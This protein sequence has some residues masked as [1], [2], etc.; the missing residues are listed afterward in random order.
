MKRSHL[1]LLDLL[2]QDLEATLCPGRTI[3]SLRGL[4]KEAAGRPPDYFNDAENY[5]KATDEALKAQAAAMKLLAEPR[6]WEAEGRA[7]ARDG[8][9]ASSREVAA[10]ST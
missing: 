1:Q 8:A 7:G 6:S 4:R 10:R 9:G 3:A 5:R 2:V